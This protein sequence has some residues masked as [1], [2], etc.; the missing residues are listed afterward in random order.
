M[1]FNGFADVWSEYGLGGKTVFLTEPQLWYNINKSFSAGGEVEI[2][3]NFAGS[4][5]FE[6]RPT[7]AIKWN[8]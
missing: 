5:D 7:I 4:N 6:V 2:S 1:T 3:N 8:I